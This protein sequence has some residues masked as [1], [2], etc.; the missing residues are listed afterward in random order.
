MAHKR[1]PYLYL[2]AFTQEN[3]DL[4][5]GRHEETRHLAERATS[6]R[7]T[8]LFG[9]PGA[10]KSSLIQAGLTPHLWQQGIAVYTLH[11]G[12]ADLDFCPVH[13][14]QPDGAFGP[15]PLRNLARQIPSDQDA[16]LA[17]DQMERFFD[18]ASPDEVR[19]L[20][21]ELSDILADRPAL[22]VV[23][24]CRERELYQL[25]R[26][27]GHLPDVMN[28]RVHLGHLGSGQARQAIVGPAEAVGIQYQEELLSNLLTALGPDEIAAPKLQIVCRALWQHLPDGK[29]TITAQIYRSLGGARAI[30]SNHLDDLLSELSDE[31]DQDV[32]RALLKEMVELDDPSSAWKLRVPRSG[33]LERLTG[34]N[35]QRMEH[36]LAFWQ[37]HGVIRPVS[38]APAYRLSSPFLIGR[39]SE[40]AQEDKW[41]TKDVRDLL[42]QALTDHWRTGKLLEKPGLGR[43]WQHRTRMRFSDEE[44][45]LIL[46]SALARGYQWRAWVGFAAGSAVSIW[47]IIRQALE[48]EEPASRSS[49]VAALS[50]L[51]GPEVVD[52]LKTALGDPYPNVH[53][54]AR[55]T[56]ARLKTPQAYEALRHHPPPDMVLVPEGTFIMGSDRGGDESPVREV[57]LDTFY[58]DRYPVTNAEYAKFVQETGH[59]PPEHWTRQGGTY[60]PGRDSHPVAY[61]CWFDARDYAAWAR[62]RLPTEAEWE[63]AARGTDGRVYPWGDR[64]NSQY[65]NTDESEYWDTTPVDAFSS[66]GESPYGVADMAG[67]V[68]EWVS[69]WYDRDYYSHAPDRNPQGPEMGKTKVVR[70]GSWD[71]SADEARCAV[72]NHEYP[73]PRHGLIG[74]RCAADFFPEED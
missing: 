49:A 73:G 7:H 56:L 35:P 28:V 25:D 34:D 4:F 67:N 44:L 72:R 47:P 42:R 13:A 36:L 8:V 61:V 65:C 16:V 27:A 53:G 24:V 52:L 26:F 66:D 14:P 63:K 59:P 29:T 21:A 22:Y 57:T 33:E 39:V 31:E 20:A 38:E 30:L 41:A 23:W 46:R 64:F 6:H 50:A 12:E 40:W 68:W 69:D 45:A 18:R 37:T 11:P 43:L 74:F 19:S 32:A 60:L 9:P 10:G 71:F 2:D 58:I 55:E 15:L 51:Q 3:A 48:S 62:K 5:F 70:G 54:L 17:F 1:C